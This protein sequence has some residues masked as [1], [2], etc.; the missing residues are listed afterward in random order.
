MFVHYIPEKLF[1][2]MKPLD[3]KVVHVGYFRSKK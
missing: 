2:K 3:H 1:V